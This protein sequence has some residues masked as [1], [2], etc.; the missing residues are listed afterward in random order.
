MAEAGRQDVPQLEA[1][2]L[3]LHCSVQQAARCY[4]EA[5]IDAGKA[6]RLI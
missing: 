6:F 4:N 5:G 2:R 3:S 1:T